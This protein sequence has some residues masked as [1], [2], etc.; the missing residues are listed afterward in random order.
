MATLIAGLHE[1]EINAETD[2]AS[3]LVNRAMAS[4]RASRDRF[5]LPEAEAERRI[6]AW[7]ECV[8]DRPDNARWGTLTALDGVHVYDRQ[9]IAEMAGVYGENRIVSATLAELVGNSLARP[10]EENGFKAAVFYLSRYLL[11]G[12]LVL[13]SVVALYF[14]ACAA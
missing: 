5:S 11:G 8:L 1:G 14:L 6:R 7:V 3:A 9:Q 13:A 4:Y 12:G 10:T 2:V